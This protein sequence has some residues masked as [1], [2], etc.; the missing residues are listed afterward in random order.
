ME[1]VDC[2]VLYYFTENPTQFI[3]LTANMDKYLPNEFKW[4]LTPPVLEELVKRID[5]F[6]FN[7][8]SSFKDTVYGFV[9]VSNICDVEI[10]NVI[11]IL[12]LLNW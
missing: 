4:K 6:Y 11:D 1:D 8:I 10:V 3:N 9:D 12:L 5:K 7:N 2:A